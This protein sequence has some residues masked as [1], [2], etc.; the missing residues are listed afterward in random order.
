MML[1]QFVREMIPGNC[2]VFHIDKSQPNTGAS[3]LSNVV[4]IALTGC[5]STMA[6]MPP[7][8]DEFDKK[9]LGWLGNGDQIIFFDNIGDDIDI[10]AFAGALTAPTYTA[11]VLRTNDM[12]TVEITS[13]W[14]TAANNLT[15]SE[16][17]ERRVVPIR[18]DA[19][20]SDPGKRT[21]KQN[22][23]VPFLYE[24]RTAIVRSCL[25]IIQHWIDSGKPLWSKRDQFATKMDS[26]E[27]WMGV[28]GGIL[29]S[30]GVEGFLEN[31]EAFRAANGAN[32]D[33]T[34]CD[35]YEKLHFQFFAHVF[36]PKEAFECLAE[37]PQNP[38]TT[39]WKVH[40][41]VETR[42]KKKGLS[43]LLSKLKG[44]TVATTS[45][46]MRIKRVGHGKYQLDIVKFSRA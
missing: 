40:V 41:P 15:V 34:F 37:D 31:L 45:G 28:M 30:A 36:T 24:Q 19:C 13:L 1:Q 27:A 46:E 43:E 26:Y 42:D 22:P 23:L 12:R 17:I 3:Y 6:T 9:M 18:L 29:E 14:L 2:P 10:A 7:N 4:S 44:K 8:Q 5:E 32:K 33:E 25:T 38:L 35:M 20:M 21:F 11:R 39:D 16:E